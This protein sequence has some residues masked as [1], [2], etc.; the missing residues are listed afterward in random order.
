MTTDLTLAEVALIDAIRRAKLEPWRVANQ[1]AVYHDEI[2]T[3]NAY[4]TD[5]RDVSRGVAKL[6]WV[7]MDA[8]RDVG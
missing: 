2:A 6:F 8:I 5:E 3:S 1:L 4:T 7:S